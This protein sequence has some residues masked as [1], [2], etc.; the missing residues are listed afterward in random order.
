MCSDKTT[1]RTSEPAVSADGMQNKSNTELLA[2]IDR[3]LEQGEDMDTERLEQCLSI[4]D[5]RAPVMT[6]YTPEKAWER[7]QADHP[8]LFEKEETATAGRPKRAKKDTVPRKYR[9][10]KF[11]RVLEIAAM[12]SLVLVV[13]ANAVRVNPIKAFLEWADEIVQVYSDPSGVMELPEDDPSEFHT[14]EE[15]LEADGLSADG[16]PRWVPKDYSLFL[17]SSNC[18]DDSAKYSAFYKSSRGELLIGVVNYYN[19]RWSGVEEREDNSFIYK[20]DGTDFFLVSNY[21]QCKAGWQVNGY[22]Y[23][24][25]G[26]ITDDEIQRMIDSIKRR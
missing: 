19:P 7:L 8:L 2:E 24:I 6:D 3:I 15:A 21:E 12:L 22:S 26:Q 14:L 20:R 25:R 18:T 5:G 23:T 10:R 4:L 11:L 9:G 16:L 13:T 17:V 1:L